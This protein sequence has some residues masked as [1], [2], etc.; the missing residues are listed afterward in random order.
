MASVKRFEEL[1]C[2]K[3]ARD[4]VKLIYSNTRSGA[5]SKDYGFRNQIC[6][7][8]VSVMS[9]IAEGFESQTHVKFVDYLGHAKASAG[10]VKSQFYVAQDLQYFS[11]EDVSAALTKAEITSRQIHRLVT[12]LKSLPN[13]YRVR[14][15]QSTYSIELEIQDSF[16]L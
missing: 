3:S 9:N 14:E 11:T 2:W 7:A 5:V 4:L 15:G 12:Y 8:A 10:E 6:R 16:E 13:L 1:E